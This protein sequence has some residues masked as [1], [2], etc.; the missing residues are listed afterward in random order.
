[1]VF[2]KVGPVK[3]RTSIGKIYLSHSC[4][5]DHNSTLRRSK[6]KK[7]TQFKPYKTKKPNTKVLCFGISFL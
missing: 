5:L 6:N 3:G 4:H 1:M 7:A 2:F